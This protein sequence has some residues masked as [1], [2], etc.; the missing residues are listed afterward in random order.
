VFTKIYFR[1][2]NGN[3]RGEKETQGGEKNL[4]LL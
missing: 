2:K 1:G 4:L 3:M